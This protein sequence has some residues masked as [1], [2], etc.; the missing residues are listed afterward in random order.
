V[1]LAPTAWTFPHEPNIEEASGPSKTSDA[2][3]LCKSVNTDYVNRNLVNAAGRIPVRR[4][5]SRQQAG[6]DRAKA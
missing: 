2:K 3:K 4:D 5:G 1:I 6:P